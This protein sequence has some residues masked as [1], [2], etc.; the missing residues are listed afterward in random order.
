MARSV[1][2]T[3]TQQPPAKSRKPGTTK[4]VA[5]APPV[6]AAKP[7]AAPKRVPAAPAAGMVSKA[8]LRAQIEKLERTNAT[9][10]AK[11][12]EINKAARAAV[13]RIG[14]LEEQLAQATKRAASPAAQRPAKTAVAKRQPREIDP[15]D[16]VPPGVAVLEPQ[17][18]DQEAEV[19]LENLEEHLGHETP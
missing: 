6:K 7:A 11:S 10:R 17:P 3:R 16:A 19:A 18:L 9:L 15:G 13:L 8:D 1:K 2:T 14:E 12:R 5:A 4:P